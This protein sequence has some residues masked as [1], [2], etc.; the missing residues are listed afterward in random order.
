[1]CNLVVL[2]RVSLQFFQLP[3]LVEG[4]KPKTKMKALRWEHQRRAFS[5]R[6]CL[7]F[8][9]FIL[10]SWFATTWQGSHVGGQYNKNCLSKNLHKN[11]FYFP[12]ERNAFVLNHQHGRH[13]VTCKQAIANHTSFFAVGLDASEAITGKWQNLFF[14]E[15]KKDQTWKTANMNFNKHLSSRWHASFHHNWN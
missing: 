14:T 13:D 10:S 12:G 2:K 1:M 5:Q 9:Y 15:S 11:I 8:V 4:M 6:G 7:T 3:C